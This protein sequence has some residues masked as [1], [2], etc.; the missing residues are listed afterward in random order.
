MFNDLT[1]RFTDIN[2]FMLCHSD[3]NDHGHPVP[4]YGTSRGV[5]P[6]STQVQVG[7]HNLPV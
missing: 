1:I 6:V 3:P 2:N 4:A 7:Y 5:M